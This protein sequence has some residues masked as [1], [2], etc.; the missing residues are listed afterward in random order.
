MTIDTTGNVGIGT[1]EPRASLDVSGNTVQDR[2]KGGMVK[3]MLYVDG[4]LVNPAIVRCYNGIT[5]ASTGNCGFAVSRI[6]RGIYQISF[7]FQVSDR[8]VSIAPRLGSPVLVGTNAINF[9]ANFDFNIQNNTTLIVHTFYSG[10]TEI[11]DEGR[12]MLFVY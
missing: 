12:F 10:N 2:D 3:A 11:L 6:S 9:G 8:F 1:A 5:G 7:G 4:T